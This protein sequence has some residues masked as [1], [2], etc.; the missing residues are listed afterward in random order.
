MPTRDIDI[1]DRTF[2]FGVRVIKFVDKLPRTL[3]ATEWGKQLLRS[4]TSIAS[5]E[6][7]WV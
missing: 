6:C 4:G 1:Q 3:S 7:G 5:P 2:Q